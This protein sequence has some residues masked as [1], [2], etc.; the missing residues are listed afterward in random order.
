MDS[1]LIA[2]P[3]LRRQLQVFT[4]L[5]RSPNASVTPD[6]LVMVNLGLL[7][8]VRTEAELAFVLGHE[9]SHYARNHGLRRIAGQENRKLEDSPLANDLY[10][11]AQERE[12]DQAGFTRL[13]RS[14]YTPAAALT[15]LGSLSTSFP[16]RPLDFAWLAPQGAALPICGGAKSPDAPASTLGSHPLPES[17]RNALLTLASLADTTG[18]AHFLIG[19]KRFI[20]SQSIARYHIARLALQERSYE[21][22]ITLAYNLWREGPEQLFP[23]QIAARALYGLSAYADAGRLYEVHFPPTSQNMARLSCLIERLK[24][25]ELNAFALHTFW[26]LRAQGDSSAMIWLQDLADRLGRYYKATPEVL[27]PPNS[28]AASWL[29][30]V[31]EDQQLATVLERLVRRGWQQ[32]STALPALHSKKIVLIAAEYQQIEGRK[33]RFPDLEKG[34]RNRQRF[35][36]QLESQLSSLGYEVV[37]LRYDDAKRYRQFVFLQQW[38][39]EKRLHG[40]LPIVVSQP[41]IQQQL[42]QAFQTPLFLWPG[43]VVEKDR[44]PN[45][46]LRLFVGLPILPYTLVNVFSPKYNTNVYTISYRLDTGHALVEGTKTIPYAARR[47]V[48][49]A[50]LYD[51]LIKL[52]H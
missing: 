7:A 3:M 43:L 18:T 20:H 27:A 42:T 40:S 38:E 45:K 34:A 21:E 52:P 29:T 25:R 44:K 1:L 4:V 32:D 33:H 6:G 46:A 37:H 9:V 50:A 28:L 2:E 26:K 23:K 12:A 51:L 41:E 30:P 17:R 8:R 31:F 35:K 36:Q 5:E 10:N 11:Q 22:A 19:K 48:V 39:K 24:P 14:R 15:V 47:D 13:L 49:S 16:S